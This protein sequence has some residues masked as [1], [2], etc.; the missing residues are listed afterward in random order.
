MAAFMKAGARFID[1]RVRFDV[2]QAL[3]WARFQS[4][5]EK[6]LD[7][8]QL[9]L[10]FAAG[11]DV[12]CIIDK[13]EYSVDRTLLDRDTYWFLKMHGYF[14]YLR[15]TT[16]RLGV[17]TTGKR[18]RQ[19]FFLDL[20]WFKGHID[21]YNILVPHSKR[22]HE[23]STISGV[24]AAAHTGKHHL[25][26]YLESRI[27]DRGLDQ[28]VI[29][30]VA[31]SV[32]ALQDHTLAMRSLAGVCVNLD[33]PTLGISFC[34]FVT[35]AN[36]SRIGVLDALIHLGVGYARFHTYIIEYLPT[37]KPGV[38]MLL[39]NRGGLGEI[40]EEVLQGLW[41][42]SLMSALQEHPIDEELIDKILQSFVP[43]HTMI[44]GINLIQ[45][46]IRQ[47]LA[48]DAVKLLYSRGVEI[49]SRPCP[50]TGNTMLHDAVARYCISYANMAAIVEFLMENGANCT[51]DVETGGISILE[52][53]VKYCPTGEPPLD[54]FWSLFNKGAIVKGPVERFYRISP[55]LVAILTYHQVSDEDVLRLVELGA[56]EYFPDWE[57]ESPLQAAILY[58]RYKVAYHLLKRGADI[59]AP[60]CPERGHTALQAACRPLVGEVELGF[61]KF[62]LDN[63]AQVNAPGSIKEEGY[64]ALQRAAESGSVSAVCLLLDAQADVNATARCH[65]ERTDAWSEFDKTRLYTALD[66]A[67][68]HGRLDIIS[69]LI[70]KAQSARQDRMVTL[71]TGPSDW[72][73]RENIMLSRSCLM[74]NMQREFG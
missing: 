63:G 68:A 22:S 7:P 10:L 11:F 35:A 47:G 31:L 20:L 56:D 5:S 45:H 6:L 8:K 39:I 43:V 24:L 27:G 36:K 44:D 67:A 2:L 3:A 72:L 70:R 29:L 50:Q 69:I 25:Q 18:P 28:Q 55:S 19:I 37:W 16:G 64:T 53:L 71:I 65:L 21:L 57:C 34:P 73:T 38:L 9:D 48:A 40:H 26:T 74:I 12:D 61:V 4:S 58:G 59:N 51:M 32:A 1:F 30:E 42:G 17:E 23:R 41:M 15:D 46:G 66:V 54:L 33:T 49:H 13:E 62:L 14:P 52:L 60:A